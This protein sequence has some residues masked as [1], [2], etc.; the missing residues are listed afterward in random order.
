M[1]SEKQNRKGQKKELATKL[2]ET[3]QTAL[4]AHDGVAGVKM[5]KAIRNAAEKLAKKMVTLQKKRSKSV[6]K[7]TSPTPAPS[8]K[9][10]K[11]AKSSEAL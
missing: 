8:K 1:A 7:T 5:S 6:K 11:S 2:A 10:A 9:K 3:L 4:V